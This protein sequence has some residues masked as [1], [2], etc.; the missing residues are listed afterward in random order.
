MG[1]Y[2]I[3]LLFVCLP[4]G[5]WAE[6]M[7]TARDAIAITE[8]VSTDWFRESEVVVPSPDGKRFLVVTKKAEFN[9]NS[10]CYSLLSFLAPLSRARAQGHQ[11]VAKFCT[12]SNRQAI[13]QV[14]WL[15]NS[16]DVLF[17][18][19]QAGRN[20]QVYR[21]NV[22]SRRLRQMTHHDT[23]V[24]SFDSDRFGAILIFLAP[25]KRTQEIA[26][27]S[28]QIVH[29]TDQRPLELLAGASYAADEPRVDRELFVQVGRQISRVAAEDF[30]TEYLPM[31]MSPD[32]GHAVLAVYKADIPASWFEYRDTSLGPYLL[33][34]RSR[35]TPSN[36]EQY[37]L[38]DV[39]ERTLTPLLDAP[40]A[41]TNT[42]IAWS[43]EGR[44]VAVS[45]T[46]LPLAG[47]D[48][49]HRKETYSAVV[50]VQS[51]RLRELASGDRRVSRWVGPHL[52][53]MTIGRRG[54]ETLE[55]WQ[56]S[57]DRWVP[58]HPSA[59]ASPDPGE[60]QLQIEEGLNSAP[61][62]VAV[63]KHGKPPVVLLDPNPQLQHIH[64]GHV[65][66]M[67]WQATDGHEVEGD[68]YL[69]PGFDDRHRYPLV[70]QTHG[71]DAHS[72]WVNGPYSSGFAAQPL[73]AKGIVVLQVG[74]APDGS[75][76]TFSNTVHEAPRQMAAYEGAIE[77][78]DRRGIIDRQRVGLFGFSRTV[79]HVEYALTHSQFHF[80]AAAVADGFDGGYV[81]DLFWGGTDY[82]AVN[83][84]APFGPHLAEWLK[85][86]P[87]F[88]VASVTTPLHLQYYGPS[89]ALGAWEWFTTLRRIGRPVDFLWLPHG[90][91]LLVRPSER[92]AAENAVVDWLCRWLKDKNCSI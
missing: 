40:K 82:D 74:F 75:D 47:Q 16:R 77:A 69:P 55:C 4:L 9:R 76:A 37:F 49:A 70:I 46:Y 34:T 35:G 88:N 68:L 3:L 59:C 81:N 57:R 50:E 86:S 62:L 28:R 67:R 12:S 66:Y 20:P 90:I 71:A 89:G 52:L 41:W 19:E 30:L 27:I 48:E 58:S 33:E 22:R 39:R 15:A 13:R 17:L 60:G 56:P 64:L 54:A 42:G 24:L 45:G 8:F 43:P 23:P 53:L 31:V 92:L 73:A 51:R 1:R 32:G 25:P 83:G 78:L 44:E 84:G 21:I 2:A 11:V 80:S 38:L 72:F 36:V 61:K 29:V 6:R 85:T 91:H 14:K 87:G 65:E 5:V 63:S 79:Y 26:Q 10:V 7:M 18:G